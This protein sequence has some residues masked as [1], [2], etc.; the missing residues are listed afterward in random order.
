MTPPTARSNCR[1]CA[2][3]A[4]DVSGLA[5][6]D[7][8]VDEG[9][10]AKLRRPKLYSAA[11]PLPSRVPGSLH[12]S[13]IARLQWDEAQQATRLRGLTREGVRDALG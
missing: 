13:E 4:G 3:T 6:F 8:L 2:T 1:T 12:N 10:E 5:W 11:P 7:A 9:S